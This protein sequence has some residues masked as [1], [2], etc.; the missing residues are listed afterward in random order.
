MKR[1][2]GLQAL[3]R[4]HHQALVLAR[5]LSTAAQGA[6]AGEDEV[7]AEISRLRADW[8]AQLAPHFAVEERE[9]LPLCHGRSAELVAQ[10]ETVRGD[11]AAM[12]AMVEA[13][14]G[15]SW[16]RDAGVL[17]ERLEAHVRFEE[18]DWF[19]ALEAALDEATLDSLSW[20]LELEPRVPIV[21]FRPD[22]AEAPGSWVAL[23]ACGHGQHIRHRPPFQDAAWV[24]TPQGR[25]DKLGT[26]L[27]CLL[28]R[29]PRLPPGADC[30]KETAVFDD[31]SVPPG[32]LASHTLRAG[33][34]GQIVVLEGRV[35]YVIEGAP[36]LSFVL[37]PGVEGN[38]APE[39]PHHVRPQ[40]GA[41]FKVRFLR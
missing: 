1:H 14:T 7:N 35:D 40:P 4:E 20:R 41:R 30:Y 38:V 22:E 11:H 26:R 25:E 8:Q 15:R 24:T 9:L 19:P 27:Q 39:G 23:L 34:W 18:R 36:A 28:C 3:S 33:T 37:R 16:T 12:Q 31:R 2:A 21:G 5:R 29:M 13:L 6:E 17:A 32:L 10:A